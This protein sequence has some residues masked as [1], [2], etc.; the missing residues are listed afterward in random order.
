MNKK[1]IKWGLGALA[2]AAAGVLLDALVLEKY[3]FEVKTFD[4]GDKSSRKKL[5]L[6]LLADLHFKHNML[7]QYSKLA[8]TLNQM[9]PDLVLIAGDTL[10]SSGGM[11]PMEQFF[12]LLRQDMPKVAIPG[13]NDYKADPSIQ[14]LKEAYAKHGC[15]FLLNETKAYT[16]KGERV[17]VTGLDDFIQGESHFKDAVEGIG[18]EAHHLLL[19]HSPLQLELV[20]KEVEQ[21]NSERSPSDQLNIRYAFAGHNHGGQVRLPSYVPK[22][23]RKSGD[24]INGWYKDRSPYLYVSKGFGTSAVPFRFFARAELTFFHYHV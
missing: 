15:D 19:I 18:K 21:L 11:L 10:D 9:Q 5:K 1:Y 16:L 7:P 23:P 8:Q 13:N 12:S 14:R 24:Y 22:L 17:V 2:V 20:Q 6:V 3:F 4:I